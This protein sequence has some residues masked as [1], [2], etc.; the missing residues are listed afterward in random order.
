MNDIHD[1][2]WGR[3]EELALNR[4]IKYLRIALRKDWPLDDSAK[5][6]IRKVWHLLQ[7]K[8]VLYNVV[9]KIPQVFVRDV[10]ND[11]KTLFERT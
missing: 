1:Y 10:R 5:K 7:S 8:E 3:F 4:I 2:V 9:Q 11:M 6:T